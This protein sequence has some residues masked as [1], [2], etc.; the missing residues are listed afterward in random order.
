[1]GNRYAHQYLYGY[2]GIFDLAGDNPLTVAQVSVLGIMMLL[3]HSLPIEGAV[4]KLTGISWCVT[5]PLRI[6]GGFILGMITNQVYLLGNW[7]QQPAEIVWQPTPASSSLFDWG[8]AQLTMLAS[9]FVIIAALMILLR[10]L[11]WCG[12]EKSCKRCYRHFKSINHR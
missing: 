1:M 6:G 9:I 2:G 7:R 10:L 3:A 5:L 4:A 8:I 12:I 11:K